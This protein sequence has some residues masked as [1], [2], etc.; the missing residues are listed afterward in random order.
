MYCPYS[1]VYHV[2]GGTLNKTSAHKTY[3]NFRN[4]L[5]LLCKN[6]PPKFFFAKLITR[7]LMD[8]LAGAK[9][10]FA[11]QFSHFNAVLRAHGSFY[12][13]LGKTLEKRRK[14]KSEIK[15]Y[16]TTAVYL[17]SI[18][19]DFYLRGK[20]TFKEIDLKDRFMKS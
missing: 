15:H 9:F 5:I 8:G 19:A 11:G 16:T 7:M 6:H 17:H 13:T 2:G 20:K 3:L 12:K 14:L 10:L 1:T 18:V 4:N